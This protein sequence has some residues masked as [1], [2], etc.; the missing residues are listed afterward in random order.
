MNEEVNVRVKVVSQY[1]EA[2]YPYTIS[3]YFFCNLRANVQPASSSNMACDIT[4]SRNQ[5][6]NM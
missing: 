5:L 1:I 6:L 4:S 2:E 3:S